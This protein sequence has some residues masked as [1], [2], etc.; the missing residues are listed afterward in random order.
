MIEQIVLV[1]H[2][3]QPFIL[4]KRMCDKFL[5]DLTS[6]HTL[7]KSLVLVSKNA[8]ASREWLVKTQKLDKVCLCNALWPLF[9]SGHISWGP[10]QHL[11]KIRTN[12]VPKSH[13][14]RFFFSTD[15]NGD[16]YS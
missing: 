10:Y 12:M 3:K 6:S 14:F 9:W 16:T 4:N 2:E 11:N 7:S 8:P 1:Y 13:V 15:L 5:S